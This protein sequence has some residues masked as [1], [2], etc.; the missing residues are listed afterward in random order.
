MVTTAVDGDGERL[1]ATADGGGGPGQ[2]DEAAARRLIAAWLAG[3][4]EPAAD[5]ATGPSG[6]S[7]QPARALPPGWTVPRAGA[8]EVVTT[9]RRLALHG[10]SGRARPV[11]GT[12]ELVLARVLVVDEHPSAPTWTERERVELAGWV[13]V[14]VRRFGEDGVQ[15]LTAA[16]TG[17]P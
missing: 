11:P 9:A 5:P 7:A 16:L 3:D 8:R 1:A 17:R 4:A 13:A 12:D 2:D 10:V 6:T 15:R 14:L